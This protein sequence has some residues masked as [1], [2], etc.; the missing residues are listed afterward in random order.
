MG[1]GPV[2]SADRTLKMLFA[3][4]RER[5]RDATEWLTA[6]WRPFDSRCSLRA[7]WRLEV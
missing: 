4:E 2:A 7:G 1:W 3:G 6:G 5:D